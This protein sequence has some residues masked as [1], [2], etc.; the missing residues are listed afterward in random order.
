MEKSAKTLIEWVVNVDIEPQIF[1]HWK[2][3]DTKK[4]KN[5]GSDGKA[6]DYGWYTLIEE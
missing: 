5:F 3:R 1:I 2:I 6:I 4:G